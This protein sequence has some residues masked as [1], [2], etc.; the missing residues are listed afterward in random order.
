M[1]NEPSRE[2]GVENTLATTKDAYSE[3]RSYRES[4]VGHAADFANAV[5][6][7]GLFCALLGIYFATQGVYSAAVIS[8]LW[9]TFF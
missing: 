4:V 6:L 3:T 2:D 5:T 8:L 9:A 1:S 7:A